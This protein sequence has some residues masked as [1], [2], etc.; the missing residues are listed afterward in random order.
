MGALINSGGLVVVAV[1]FL[2]GES[3]QV[4]APR[5][6]F[7]LSRGAAIMRRY[8]VATSFHLACNML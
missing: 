5:V 6:E 1:L 3:C 2:C 8:F 4:T 7:G